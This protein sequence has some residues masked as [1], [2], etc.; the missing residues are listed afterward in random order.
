MTKLMGCQSWI[1]LQKER[2]I[3]L[4]LSLS[5]SCLLTLRE[6]TYQGTKDFP[7]LRV[8]K[9]L[10]PPVQKPVSNLMLPTTKWVN[11]EAH[12]AAP[13]LSPVESSKGTTPP[14][15]SFS[16]TL[17]RLWVTGAQPSY[18]QISDSQEMWNN[19]ILKGNI[20]G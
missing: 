4:G 3:H 15:Y 5:I 8:S 7:W 17:E 9:D 16:A 1:R 20:W 2:E 11:L 13:A 19:I 14:S 12:A 18:T 10:R 6:D